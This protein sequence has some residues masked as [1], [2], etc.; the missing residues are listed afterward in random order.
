MMDEELKNKEAALIVFAKIPKPNRVKTRLTTLLSPEDAAALYEAFLLD[1]LDVYS[2]LGVDVRL[3]YSNPVAAI[4]R[5]LSPP[6]A[7][8]FEQVGDGLGAR[9]ANAFAETFVAGYQRAVIIGT[10]HPTLPDAFIQ[11]A[12]SLLE[13]PRNITI[14]PS[15]DGGYYLLGMNEFYPDIFKNMTYS[16]EHVFE[17][18]IAR[19][20][21]LDAA[22]N[23]LPMWFD[24]DTPDSLKQLIQDLKTSQQPLKRTRTIVNQLIEAF[25]ELIC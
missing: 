6:E 16:H 23:I 3:Y 8:L 18:T 5:R 24:V 11:Q 15:D 13:A 7:A 1:A 20:G 10:D 21:E 25:P 4:P 12:F 14:G 9:M 19:V 17:D 2:T 22:I